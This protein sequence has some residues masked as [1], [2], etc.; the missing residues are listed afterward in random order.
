V[1]PAD[2][3]G[4]HP[5]VARARYIDQRA[6]DELA[7][8]LGEV[9]AACRGHLAWDEGAAEQLLTEVRRHPVTPGLFGLYSDLVDAVF[10]D[11]LDEAQALI[12]AITSP[13]LRQAA[14]RQVV[15][16][17]DDHLGPG[18]ADR[19]RRLLN[20]DP[21]L[22]VAVAPV[23]RAAFDRAADF[24][25]S[26]EA[27]LAEG[28]P[29]I[30]AEI[31]ALVR[32]TIVVQSRPT[33]EYPLVFD[34]ASTFYLW[35]AVFLNVER[36]PTRIALAEQLVHEV[37][38]CHLFGI[39]LGAP[40]VENPADERYESP[41]REDPRPMDGVVHAAYVLARMMYCLDRLIASG[42]LTPDETEA[43]I[44]AL[45]RDRRLFDEGLVIVDRNA[46]FTP[47][48]E[49]V[50]NHARRFVEAIEIRAG[51]HAA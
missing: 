49:A 38:H 18:Q 33:P 5:D 25:A 45:Q 28:A 2:L 4:F 17:T 48:G 20:D 13:P 26:A 32:Q 34:G 10:A 29:E 14:R 40:L 35:G 1:E 3:F 46:R 41:L 43:A 7:G 51:A 19:Y 30:A 31:G 37:G 12:G 6:R 16:L 9:F 21:A 50:F 47:T 36:L 15:T 27:L 8:S 39:T 42:I 11:R 23:D 24:L 22:V 44:A